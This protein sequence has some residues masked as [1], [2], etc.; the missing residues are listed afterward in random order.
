LIPGKAPSEYI[1]QEFIELLKSLYQAAQHYNDEVLLF[2][3]PVH[4]VH[5]NE[6]DYCWQFKG[7]CHTKTALANTGRRRLNIIGAINPVTLQPTAMLIEDNCCEEV[8]VAFLEEIKKQYSSATTICIIL[9]N[10]RYQR[11]YSVQIRAKELGISLIYLPPYCP[12]LNLIERLWRF[13][14]KKV[15]KNKFY[16]TFGEFEHSVG[17]FFVNFDDYLVQL[18]SLLSFKF[19]IIKAN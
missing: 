7:R 2:I 14:K 8:I 9:D 12:N 10:A 4:Q 3:D 17:E 16:E 6:N 1:Q 15:M 13:F 5:N 19:G 11:A 18:K